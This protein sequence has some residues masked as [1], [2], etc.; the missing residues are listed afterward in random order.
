MTT[1]QQMADDLKTDPVLA[2]LKA[3][4][5]EAV[6]SILVLTVYADEVAGFM[7]EAELEHML[8]E[9]PWME[10]KEARAE[11]FVKEVTDKAKGV[12]DEAGFRAIADAAASKLKDPV[13]RE[14]AYT[15]AY[16]LACIDM[17]VNKAEHLALEWLAD[18]LEIPEGKRAIQCA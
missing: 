14:K 11:A 4:Q 6:I 18:A 8:Y 17:N 12:S 5:I 2:N 7:E 1:W 3:D 9:L 13:V 10:D 16:N 15:M